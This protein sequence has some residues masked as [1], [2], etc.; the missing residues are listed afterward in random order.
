MAQ[1]IFCRL[2]GYLPLKIY[3]NFL[4][5][6]SQ[7]VLLKGLLLCYRPL[8]KN[9]ITECPVG[10]SHQFEGPNRMVAIVL[11]PLGTDTGRA[12]GSRGGNPEMPQAEMQG[13]LSDDAEK[14]TSPNSRNL[15]MDFEERRLKKRKRMANIRSLLVAALGILL[16]LATMFPVSGTIAEAA[17][18]PS[19]P[20]RFIVPT[21]AGG[22]TDVLA[23]LIAA[24]LTEHL[25]SQVIVENK[26]GAGGILAGEM[27]AKADPDG[28]TLLF[29][30][31]T[32]STQPAFQRLPYDSVKSFM[33]IA[34][35]VTGTN[36]LTV[37]SS[38]PA[39]SVKELVALAKQKPGEII[40]VAPG[41]GSAPHLGIELFRMMSDIYIKIV[42]FKGGSLAVIDQIGG[43]SHA[44]IGGITQS[45][46][47]IKSGKVRVLASCGLKRSTFLPDVPTMMESGFPGYELYQWFG[48]LAPAGTP[49]PIIDRLSQELKAILALDEMKK[50]ILKVGAEADFLGPTE[51]GKFIEK[52]MATWARVVK[53]ANIKLE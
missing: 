4:G 34:R 43:H 19:K 3:G 13:W 51:F 40:F 30:P 22:S 1:G 35:V 16:V 32:F 46:P 26:G 33:P 10:M 44:T 15:P 53:E 6:L 47:Y 42:Q 18:Y 52:E 50:Q 24:K 14:M 11:I 37:N 9:F 23:R 8:Q 48:L 38:V 45:V 49:S 27:V 5:F 12:D 25:G 7:I 36:I 28:Y 20:V 21:A 17:S 29:I 39:N 41:V 2:A 31:A